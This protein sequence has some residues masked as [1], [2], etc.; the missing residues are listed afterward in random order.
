MFKYIIFKILI[1]TLFSSSVLAENY[2]GDCKKIYDYLLSQ[3][4]EYVYTEDLVSCT[5]NE[6]GQVENM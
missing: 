1:I 5:T 4:G 6:E 3:S 2:T